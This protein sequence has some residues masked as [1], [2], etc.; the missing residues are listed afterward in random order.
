MSIV[1]NNIS[2]R[3][4]TILINRPDKQNALNLEAVKN[5]RYAFETFEN[6]NNLDVAILGGVGKNFC[7]GYDLNEML[8][9][10]TGMPK[11]QHIEQMLWPLG[12]KL[13][14][15]KIVI[16]A[17][18][19]H[20]AG[21]GYELALKC[22]FRIGDRDSRMGF[23]NRRFGIPILNGGT[24]ILP[25]LVGLARASELIATGKAQLA[26]DALQYGVLTYLSNVGCALGRSL[27]LARCLAKFDQ[28]ALLH[29]LRATELY[30]QAQTFECLQR[31]R[32]NSLRY[33]QNCGPLDVA[34]KFLKGEL[35]RHGNYDM[36]NLLKPD[37]EV[38]L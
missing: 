12:F 25:Q 13:S 6:D 30:L 7:S 14:N 26:H 28:Q 24:V 21:F 16:A 3:I 18:E 22:H 27:N 20:A 10:R 31:E 34:C 1:V 32:D 17:I 33:L 2:K 4:C 23:M 9:T 8:D 15:K 37:P 19:G 11:I 38:T 29:D 5:L 36:G 35:G